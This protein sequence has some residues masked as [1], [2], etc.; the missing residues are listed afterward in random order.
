M[1]R[2]PRFNT[3][4][5]GVLLSALGLAGCASTAV[6]MAE[7]RRIVGTLDAVRID[8]QVSVDQVSPGAHIP[9][10]YEITNQR[11]KAIAVAELLPDTSYDA[12]SHTFT[13][14]IGSEV[15]GN[16]MLPRLVVIEPGEKKTFSTMARV[17]Y[18]VPPRGDPQGRPSASFR[19]KLNFLGDTEPFR[20]LIGIKE[21]AVS[22]PKL[23]DALF[24]LWLERNEVVYTNTI[25]M[26]WATRARE[27]GVSPDRRT[28]GRRP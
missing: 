5:C 20:E 16:S 21:V 18:V 1:K 19:L 9:I 13:V 12:E 14:S 28:P 11:D 27:I 25:P 26:R 24:P 17:I 3:L 2:G 6:D 15:P 7:P 4:V 8:A 22:D 23:A 10:T